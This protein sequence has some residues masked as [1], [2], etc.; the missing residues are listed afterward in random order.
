MNARKLSQS[1]ESSLQERKAALVRQG[2]AYRSALL[3]SAK[4]AQ[5]ALDPGRLALHAVRYAGRHVKPGIAALVEGLVNNKGAAFSSLAASAPLLA[6]LLKSGL[7]MVVDKGKMKRLLRVLAVAVP[8]AS[9]IY[10]VWRKSAEN[11]AH[12]SKSG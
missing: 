9:L 4:T 3:D 7:S 8:A 12:Q 5:N 2:A 11:K 1:A 6:P 10:L